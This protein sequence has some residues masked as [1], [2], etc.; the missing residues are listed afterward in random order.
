M[1]SW[2]AYLKS[3]RLYFTFLKHRLWV[4]RAIPKA[5]LFYCFP[6][7][8]WSVTWFF[9]PLAAGVLATGLAAATLAASSIGPSIFAYVLAFHILAAPIALQVYMD[10]FY[11]YIAGLLYVLGNARMTETFIRVA[12]DDLA[13]WEALRV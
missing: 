7:G 4:A 10:T 3:S 2:F 1:P 11:G 12:E 13:E 6:L 8:T 5:H 9:L